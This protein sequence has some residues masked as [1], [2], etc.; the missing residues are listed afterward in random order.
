[1]GLASLVALD[2]PHDLID[3]EIR[4]LDEVLDPLSLDRVDVVKIDVQGY[5]VATLRGM[6]DCLARLRPVVILEYDAWAWDRA[7]ATLPDAFDLFQAA[8]YDVFRLD[9][10]SKPLS[11]E[12]SYPD[13]LDVIAIPQE[14]TGSSSARAVLSS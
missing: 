5:E 11:R 7:S 1:M 14:A 10:Y 12:S 9:D 6:R 4:T 8:G 3:V 13:F 2:T